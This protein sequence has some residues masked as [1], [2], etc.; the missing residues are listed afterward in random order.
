MRRQ[1]RKGVVTRSTVP[2][3]MGRR[4]P[5]S[6]FCGSLPGTINWPKLRLGVQKKH[7]SAGNLEPRSIFVCLK[8]IPLWPLVYVEFLD[9]ANQVDKQKS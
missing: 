2:F 3:H 8:C 9:I 7:I 4:S 5:N 6:G 1:Q